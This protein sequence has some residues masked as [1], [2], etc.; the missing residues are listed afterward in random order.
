MN[1]GLS[2]IKCMKDE[3]CDCIKD[4]EER[5]THSKSTFEKRFVKKGKE[6]TEAGKNQNAE[7]IRLENILFRFKTEEAEITKLMSAENCDDI[8]ELDEWIRECLESFQKLFVAK[9]QEQTKAGRD[10]D[11]EI[12]R[13]KRIQLQYSY[14]F[15]PQQS[16]I[17]I[18]ALCR[19]RY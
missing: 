13:L 5:I 2:I 3:G 11:E 9:G 16:A 1:D 10:K 15:P 6:Q 17:P 7:I 12:K 8:A 4:L 19:Y 14:L 18:T